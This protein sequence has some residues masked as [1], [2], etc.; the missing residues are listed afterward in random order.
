MTPETYQTITDE[1][2]YVL[3]QQYGS[4]AK[5][6]RG[7]VKRQYLARLARRDTLTMDGFLML[8][9]SVAADDVAIVAQSVIDKWDGKGDWLA[10]AVA[11]QAEYA[12]DR[13]TLAGLLQ[14]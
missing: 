4:H 7:K 10:E 1:L 8:C 11:M 3:P 9:D 2:R 13:D 14:F 12:D 6:N 5:R